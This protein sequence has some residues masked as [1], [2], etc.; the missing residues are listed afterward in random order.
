V[1]G[2]QGLTERYVQ[3]IGTEGTVDFTALADVD[4]RSID[5]TPETRPVW[6]DLA[7]RV[8]ELQVGGPGGSVSVSPHPSFPGVLVLG[9]TTEPP[10]VAPVVTVQPASVWSA[11]GDVATFT[12][13]AS[14]TP[15]PTVQWQ[16]SASGSGPWV[17][18]AGA[19]SPSYSTPP[20]TYAQNGSRYR[21][22]FTNSAGSA[23]SSA[24]SLSVVD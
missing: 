23:T 20:L 16:S 11:W 14:G 13:A 24:A 5:M 8:D 3:V 6:Q 18:I 4:P 7:A 1:V 22:V 15:A 9:G 17:D 19:T 10:S 21:A 2:V 12:A